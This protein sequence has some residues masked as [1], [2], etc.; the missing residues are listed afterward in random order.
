M[1]LLIDFGNSRCKWA[2]LN[3]Q[4]ALKVNAY[5]YKSA[6]NIRRAEE[7]VEKISFDL[8]E[9]IH[10]V[11]VLGDTFDKAFDVRANSLAG[12]TTKFHVSQANSFGV[13]LAYA[14]P[15]TYG[16]DRYA[17]LVAAYHKVPGAKIVIDCG[18][19]TTVDVV[20]SNGKHLGGLII[21][22]I[23]LM[24]SALANKASGITMP[25]SANSTQLF[26]DN[27]ADAVYSGS[28]LVHSHGLCAIIEDIVGKI[29]QDVTVYVTGGESDTIGLA[30]S[31]YV[32]CPGLVLEGL[33]IMQGS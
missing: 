6:D 25:K 31:E 23:Q 7:V 12:I 19:A 21:P 28:A 9:E 11:S 24:C 10:A 33:Q 18:T 5:A 3:N 1:K 4:D 22:G 8:I 2:C 29:N 17:A 14:N 20:D 32:D 16:A 30:S 27:T 15:L 26:N 13:T